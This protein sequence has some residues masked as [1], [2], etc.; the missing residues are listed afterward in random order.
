MTSKVGLPVSPCA[1][2]RARSERMRRPGV[3]L[4]AAIRTAVAWL[5]MTR[6]RMAMNARY[7]RD[8]A[9]LLY[10]DDRMLADI[11]I[12]R[13]DVGAALHE[14]RRFLGRNAI[15][16]GAAARQETA[17]RAAQTRRHALP[18]TEAPPLV[19]VSRQTMETSD[20]G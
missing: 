6:Q 1:I 17:F 7:R 2:V 3:W 4:H 11:G 16:E 19:P 8:L 12:T 18:E 15:M 9:M 10:A 14:S 20:I 13:Y 5:R